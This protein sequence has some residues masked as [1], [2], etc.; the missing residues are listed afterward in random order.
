M[1]DKIL[2][3][4]WKVLLGSHLR[5]SMGSSRRAP[6]KACFLHRY[7]FLRGVSQPTWHPPK[8]EASTPK[9]PYLQQRVSC[10]VYIT[11]CPLA[12][13]QK[14]QPK[15]RGA[16]G[17]A[18][19]SQRSILPGWGLRRWGLSSRRPP[20]L[21]AP[22]SCSSE[23]QGGVLQA[24]SPSASPRARPPAR[25]RPV[26]L[27]PAGRLE[28]AAGGTA[29]WGRRAAGESGEVAGR[30]AQRGRPL[31]WGRAPAPFC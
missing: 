5:A 15:Q 11:M 22:R 18:R 6:P 25:H 26:P 4:E 12:C 7:F 30:R 24:Q 14:T 10:G 16:P 21:V 20:P 3:L 28:P 8:S 19:W 17:T 29:A 9:H 23:L 1:E 31:R 13:K 2:K 27:G